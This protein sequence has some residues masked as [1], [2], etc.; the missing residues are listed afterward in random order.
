[1]KIG[2]LQK[3]SLIDYPGEI[4]SVVFFQGCNLNCSYCHNPELIPQSRGYNYDEYEI[5]EF[6]ESRKN[7]IT[8]VVLTG[9]EPLLQ[10]ISSFIEWV[11]SLGLKVKLDT[12]G[13]MPDDLSRVVHMV[14][15][16]AMDVKIFPSGIINARSIE[17]IL[18][19]AKDYEFRTTV[20]PALGHKPEDIEK[21]ARALAGAKRYYIQ[22][23]KSIKVYDEKLK[24]TRSFTEAEMLE[25]KKA[26]QQYIDNVGVRL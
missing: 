1:M 25:F 20:V 17:I 7:Y 8:A 6:I 3:V 10:P 11:K 18:N 26:A 12:N 16:V 13:T 4:A 22:N 24:G 5:K 14:D 15:Y 2:G 23:F 19:C 21:I 9:G